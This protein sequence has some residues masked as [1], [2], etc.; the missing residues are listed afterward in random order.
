MR[1]DD[2]KRG[3]EWVS[4][5][6]STEILS[7]EKEGVHNKVEVQANVGLALT[8]PLSSGVVHLNRLF[9]TYSF[10]LVGIFVRSR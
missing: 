10:H 9:H 3:G 6:G 4:E 1:Q 7:K 5:K 2:Q 8:H